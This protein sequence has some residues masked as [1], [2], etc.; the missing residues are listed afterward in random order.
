MRRP[1]ERHALDHAFGTLRVSAHGSFES[2]YRLEPRPPLLL[3]PPSHSDSL[4]YF[5]RADHPRPA[6][7]PSAA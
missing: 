2:A 5:R 7:I 3:P 6:I 1:I 4:A